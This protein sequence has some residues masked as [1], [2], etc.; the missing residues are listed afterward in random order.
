MRRRKGQPMVVYSMESVGRSIVE[1]HALT[2]TPPL[3][4]CCL[5]CVS[6]N[7]LAGTRMVA[8]LRFLKFNSV[9]PCGPPTTPRIAK[10]KYGTYTG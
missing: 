1:K 3:S 4:Q 7:H 8:G 9:H 10:H 2:H 5:P 6:A